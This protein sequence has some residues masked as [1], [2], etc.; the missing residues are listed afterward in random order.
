VS[1]PDFTRSSS[2]ASYAWASEARHRCVSAFC[3]EPRRGPAAPP[4]LATRHSEILP[5]TRGEEEF[6]TGPK[7]T[8]PRPVTQ[9][10]RWVSRA[11][12]SG[13][14]GSHSARRVDVLPC[15]KRSEFTLPRGVGGEARVRRVW[16]S[17][18]DGWPCVGVGTPASSVVR[19]GKAG[20]AH[21]HGAQPGVLATVLCA[22][23]C[24]QTSA[25]SMMT[26]G[27]AR[28]T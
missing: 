24:V 19:E 16:C 26:V 14:E 21:L 17:R 3:G 23:E 12:G 28:F 1:A 20:F 5:G 27:P 9:R 18:A 22:R 15:M 6:G 13:R 25:A 11:F 10:Q 7:C 2:P 8:W 4:R